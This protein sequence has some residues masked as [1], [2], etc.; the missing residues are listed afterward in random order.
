[1]V[2][3]VIEDTTLYGAAPVVS[4]QKD[5]KAAQAEPGKKFGGRRAPIS[6]GGHQGAMSWGVAGVKL[7]ATDT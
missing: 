3:D 4:E 6:N 2:P 7:S 1:L 5:Q